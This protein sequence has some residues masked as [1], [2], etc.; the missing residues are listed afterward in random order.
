VFVIAGVLAILGIILALMMPEPR[1]QAPDHIIET[2]GQPG[3][4]P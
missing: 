2:V 3:V 4:Q 1:S